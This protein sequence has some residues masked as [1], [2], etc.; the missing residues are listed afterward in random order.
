V[1]WVKGSYL[2][3]EANEDYWRGAPSIKLIDYRPIKES[4]T[5]LA[6]VV[7]GKVD[8]MSGIPVEL[9]NKLVQ[10]PKIEVVRK[11]GRRNVHLQVTNRPGTPMAD[12]R[13]RM[14]MY[15]AINEDEIIA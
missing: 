7:S 5:R 6:A 14:A 10:N 8:F 9:Y 3:L 12:I 2:K 1:E 4:A 13:V 11:P 15:M